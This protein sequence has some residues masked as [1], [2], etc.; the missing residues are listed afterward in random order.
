VQ[1][2]IVPTHCPHCCIRLAL[3]IAART[4]VR[5]SQRWWPQGRQSER[6]PGSTNAMYLCCLG[7]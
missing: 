2:A 7:L 6:G 3:N 5:N 4:A 1:A